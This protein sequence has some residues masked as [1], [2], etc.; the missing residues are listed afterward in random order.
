[1][2]DDMLNGEIDTQQLSGAAH[3]IDVEIIANI[4]KSALD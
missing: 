1:M 4:R 3:V 2:T